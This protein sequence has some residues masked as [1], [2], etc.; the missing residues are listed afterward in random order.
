MDLK[1][2]LKYSTSFLQKADLVSRADWCPALICGNRRH[3]VQNSTEAESHYRGPNENDRIE[4][5]QYQEFIAEFPDRDE[6]IHQQYAQGRYFT[7]S[8]RLLEEIRKV[9][10]NIFIIIKK[11]FY[12]TYFHLQLEVLKEQELGDL[13]RNYN[14]LLD[15]GFVDPAGQAN[16]RGRDDDDSEEDDDSDGDDDH[17]GG[18]AAAPRQTR[19][20]RQKRSYKKVSIIFK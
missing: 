16:R 14:P 20:Q 12:H 13:Y 11:I 1:E 9:T 2:I 4:Y 17:Q 18:A 15:P 5:R 10:T 8:K 7:R 6:A 3:S 19:A